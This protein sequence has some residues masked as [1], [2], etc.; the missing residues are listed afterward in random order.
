MSIDLQKSLRRLK[1]AKNIVQLQPRPDAALQPAASLE[2]STQNKFLLDTNVLIRHAAGELPPH[3]LDLITQAIILYQCTVCI[4]EICVGLSH[5]NVAHPNW[6][7][8]CS[9]WNAEFATYSEARILEPDDEIWVE[10]GLV[11]GSLSRLQHYSKTQMKDA[12]NDALIY[13]TAAK[14][15]VPVLTENRIDFDFIQQLVKR[16]KFYWF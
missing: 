16:G 14:Y 13:L 7:K 2:V 4:S 1:P 3:V 6:V 12:L 15:G 8:E 9:Y 10:A 5:R 11:T